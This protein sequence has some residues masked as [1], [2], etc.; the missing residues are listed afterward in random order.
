M[1]LLQVTGEPV[2]NGLDDLVK[3]GFQQGALVVLNVVLLHILRSIWTQTVAAQN[4]R[5][6]QL[7]AELSKRADL[8]D[9]NSKALQSIALAQQD[10]A[11]AVREMAASNLRVAEALAEVKA[12]VGKA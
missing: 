3:W 10:M 9:Q 2:V 1:F 6:A 11:G 8:V 12:R 7:A 4:Q 5:D